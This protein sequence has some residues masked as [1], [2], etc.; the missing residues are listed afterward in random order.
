MSEGQEGHHDQEG[1]WHGRHD[2]WNHPPSAA[3]GLPPP[4][5]TGAPQPPAAM[6][7]P[8]RVD[9]TYHDYSEYPI[10]QL[11]AGKKRA[12]N[13]PSKLHQILSTHEYSHVRIFG[14]CILLHNNSVH[15]DLLSID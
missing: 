5:R 13:F 7:A 15:T 12:N 3:A 14:C 9:H 6:P 2:S 10:S 11:P 4:Q 8:R 1:G